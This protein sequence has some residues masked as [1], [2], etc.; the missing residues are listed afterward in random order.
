MEEQEREIGR[1][2]LLPAVLISV[3]LTAAASFFICW[4]LMGREKHPYLTK[5]KE[6]Q[7]FVDRY[8]IGDVREEALADAVADGMINGLGDEWSYYI[9]KEK[10]RAYQEGIENAYVGIGVTIS[11]EGVDTGIR[12]ADVTAGGPAEA[13]GILAGDLITAVDGVRVRDGSDGALDMDEVTS[14]VRGSVGSVVTLTILR[15]GEE[16]DFSVTRARIK[17]VNVTSETLED[18]L[19]YIRIRN[20]DQRAA[21]DTISALKQAQ[22]DGA[23]GVIFD[24]RYNPGG[25]KS[26][27]ISILDV[28]LPEG[29]LFHSITKD[30]AVQTDYSDANHIE[31]PMAVL[32]NYHS[33]SAAEFFAAALQQYN[34]AKIV[35]SQTYGKGYFQSSFQLSD[36]SA[37]NI[38]VGK[39]T[40]PNGVSL[41]GKGVTPDQVVELSKQKEAD[42]YY[43]RLAK[44]EDE[45]LQAAI[46]L[47]KPDSTPADTD[48]AN[49]S[50]P[51]RDA[52]TE[53]PEA[54]QPEPSENTE[55]A[56]E[57][58]VSPAADSRAHPYLAKLAELQ[59]LVDRYYI[60]EPDEAALEEGL[61]AA[62]VD[63]IG[64]EWSYY[65]P[66]EDYESYLEDMNNEYVGIG[67]T[68]TSKDAEKGLLITSVV[69][70]SPADEA[71]IQ[72]GDLLLAVEGVPILDGSEDAIDS[73]ETFRRVRGEVNTDVRITVSHD[74]QAREITVTRKRIHVVN[75]TSEA[76]GDGLYYI[77]I[78]NFDAGA[79]KDTMLALVTAQMSGAKGVIFDVRYNP[80]GLKTELVELLDYILPTGPL[81]R[82]TDYSGRQHIDHSDASHIEIPMAVLVNYDS[83]SAAE[84]FAAALQEYGYAEIVG[85]QTY[86]KGRFQAAITLSDGSAVN[87]SVGSYKT[88]LGKDLVGKGI[89]PDHIVE[90]SEADE[91]ALSS[92]KL[93]F[94]DDEQL[95]TAISVLTSAED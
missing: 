34:Y 70:G 36:G 71:G 28:I 26:E 95:Q 57:Q 1:R 14:R 89:T 52:P 18:G 50:E 40:P 21:E 39:Y 30:G 35:G 7:S 93:A 19:V 64:D 68:I 33:Y 24:V 31:I 72:S 88:P 46:A 3:A 63:S 58:P 47:L 79:A 55:P 85:E 51:G 4:L 15:D 60:G 37:I 11:T 74:G 23:K 8:F 17:A 65:I 44:E 75:V 49:A 32:V 43:N 82:S 83:Y 16:R 48:D 77:H 76:L 84:F 86:G 73:D 38:S 25:L 27:L 92:G 91:M 67:I 5:V 66:A 87:L 62:F 61:A 53:T 20:F 59:D 41:V 54:T 80:G 9:P 42:L 6:I 10:Y 94:A 29:E 81:F 12:I 90:L 13:A 69:P 78:R 45:Q 2:R 56:E 22:Q